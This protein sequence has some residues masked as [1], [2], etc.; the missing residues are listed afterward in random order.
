MRG[1]KSFFISVM[2][3]FVLFAKAQTSNYNPSPNDAQL[4][5][6]IYLEK[7]IFSKKYIAHINHEGR[8]TE[9]NSQ[10]HYAYL[11]AGLTYKFKKYLRFSADYVFLYKK[12]FDIN[13]TDFR[14]SLRHQVYLDFVVRKKIHKKFIFSDRNMFQWEWDDIYSTPSGNVSQF[15]YR[16]KLTVKY[17]RGTLNPYIATEQYYSMVFYDKYGHQF[18]RSRYYLGVFYEMDAVNEFE[19]YYMLERHFN[20]DFPQNNWVIGIGFSHS[21]YSGG[22]MGKW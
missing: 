20:V 19:A 14:N 2:C 21:F 6:N 16:N 7:N 9:N 18:D 5:E 15:Y 8:I 13:N 11:D 3:L 22:I 17:D 12:T 1:K 4:W 10:F